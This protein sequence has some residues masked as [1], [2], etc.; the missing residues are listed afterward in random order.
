MF[1]EKTIEMEINY[2]NYE[3]TYKYDQYDRYDVTGELIQ[4]D[5]IY[6]FSILK[7]NRKDKLNNLLPRLSKKMID[8]ILSKIFYKINGL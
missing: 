1:Y 5:R 3:I 6:P 8:K 2:F 4:K 7:I